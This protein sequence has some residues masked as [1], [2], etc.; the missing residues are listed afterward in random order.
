LEMHR[1]D[2]GWFLEA[3]ANSDFQSSIGRVAEAVW[4]IHHSV[5]R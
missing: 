3:G 4:S 2:Q 5:P 1:K